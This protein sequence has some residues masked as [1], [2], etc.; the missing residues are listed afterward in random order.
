MI[1]GCKLLRAPLCKRKEMQ[2]MRVTYNENHRKIICSGI[3]AIRAAFAEGD[4]G[5]ILSLLLC[6]DF[7]LDPYYGHKLPYENEVFDLLQETAVKS[8]DNDV[9]E[10]CLNL[11]S[12][13][14][15]PPFTVLEKNIDSIKADNTKQMIRDFLC[16]QDWDCNFTELQNIIDELHKEFGSSFGWTMIPLLQSDGHYV[17][18]LKKELGEENELSKEMIF[19]AAR[20]EASGDVLYFLP[21]T[22]WRIYHLTCSDNNSDSF[23]L[24]REFPDIGTLRDFFRENL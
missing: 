18:E 9:T 2:S 24:Y 4:T 10:D 12:S 1:R 13:Y 21:G 17:R 14:S 6:L 20:N 19:A 15:Y 3:D 7:Y 22:V 11:L 8:S 23:P 16:E 5:A